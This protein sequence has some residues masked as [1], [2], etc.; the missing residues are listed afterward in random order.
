MTFVSIPFSVANIMQQEKIEKRSGHGDN[1]FIQNSA[2]P[3]QNEKRKTCQSWFM[4]K[5]VGVVFVL[6]PIFPR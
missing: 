6:K 1:E 3:T 2:I 5:S 4:T